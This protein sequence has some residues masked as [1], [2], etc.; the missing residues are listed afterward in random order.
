LELAEASQS[1][2]PSLDSAF[3]SHLSLLSTGCTSAASLLSTELHLFPAD[4]LLT[5]K[6]LHQQSTGRPLAAH[7]AQQTDELQSQLDSLPVTSASLLPSSASAL[8][9]LLSST[10]ELSV[11]LPAFDNFHSAH[12]APHLPSLVPPPPSA[13]PLASAL[14]NLSS[15]R[16]AVSSQLS[17][18]SRLCESLDGVGEVCEQCELVRPSGSGTGGAMLD[19]A[20]LAV[21][22][23][24]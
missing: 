11:T 16:S 22:L 13:A 24:C 6:Q 10:A 23:R 20:G 19:V 4:V 7:I 18:A 12:I 2:S 14:S 5:N 8:P 15:V 21:V 17:Y 3:D 1:S 9:A